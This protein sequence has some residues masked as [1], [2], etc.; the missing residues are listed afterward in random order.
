M[1][2]YLSNCCTAPEHEWWTGLC[3]HC[4]EHAEFAELGAAEAVEPAQFNVVLGL[5]H[6]R[7]PLLPGT[8][9]LQVN[10]CVEVGE[11]SYNVKLGQVKELEQ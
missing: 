6:V 1:T 7:K 5:S 3:F 2:T 10:E 9:E 11:N 8:Y 4:K